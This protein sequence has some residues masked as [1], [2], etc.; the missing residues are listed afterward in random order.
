M[1][2]TESCFALKGGTAINL[3]TGQQS[4]WPALIRLMAMSA[5]SADA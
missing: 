2:D 3:S 5:A 1:I 4:Y